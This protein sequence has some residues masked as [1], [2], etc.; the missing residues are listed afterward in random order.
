MARTKVTPKKEREGRTVLCTKAER[1]RIAKK[2]REEKVEK[3]GPPLLCTTLP[4]PKSPHP[5]GRWSRQWKRQR[6]RLRRLDGWRKWVSH[7]CHHQPESCP[8]WLQ[9]PGHLLQERSQPRGSSAPLWEAKPPRRN[10]S[11]LGR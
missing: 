8:R 10:S 4:Q 2:A 3:K 7:H 6:G 11:R 9:R 5:Q 1:A